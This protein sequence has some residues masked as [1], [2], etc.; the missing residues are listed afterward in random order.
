[1]IS[2]TY[3]TDLKKNLVSRLGKD[4][5]DSLLPSMNKN[6][7]GNKFKASEQVGLTRSNNKPFLAMDTN[8][9]LAAQQQ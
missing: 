3:Q 7:D 8:K 9:G 6:K 4:N 2:D 5:S 1:M